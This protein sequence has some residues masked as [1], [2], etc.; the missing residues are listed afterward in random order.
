MAIL[1]SA[2]IPLLF[3]THTAVAA[4]QENGDV[5]NDT[6]VL[7]ERVSNDAAATASSGAL[8][9]GMTWFFLLLGVFSCA[10]AG[11]LIVRSEKRAVAPADEYAIIEDIIEGADD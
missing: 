7:W 8:S 5:A 11:A 4:S 3:Y 1:R 6:V 2:I 9:F 10:L